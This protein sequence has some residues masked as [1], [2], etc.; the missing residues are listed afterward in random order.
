MKLAEALIAR[1]G[2]KRRMEELKV[3]ITRNAKTQEGDA[4]A[5]EPMALIAEYERTATQM[6]DLIQRINATNASTALDETMTIA[7][8]IARRDV[9]KMRQKVYSDLAAEA[10][11]T[12]SRYTRSE[13]RFV[14]T[15]AVADIQ[16]QADTLAREGR[17]L[18]ARLQAANWMV[19]MKE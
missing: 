7:D 17:E 4:V 3:R 18:D 12:H 9:L 15:V 1:A 11:P 16:K 14:T 2:A 5:E 10:T 6:L 19:D 13:V 8:A